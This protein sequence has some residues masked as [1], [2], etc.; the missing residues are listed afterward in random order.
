[1]KKIFLI[2]LLVLLAVV[3]TLWIYKYKRP[4]SAAEKSVTTTPNQTD[5]EKLFKL[6]PPNASE[7]QIREHSQ[8][9]A[10]LAFIG[11][12]VEINDCS[13]KPIVLQVNQGQSITLKNN[14]TQTEA[15]TIDNSNIVNITAKKEVKIKASFSK[16]PG[17]YGYRC[18]DQKTDAIVGFIAVTD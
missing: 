14:G 6:P 5:E 15:I 18:K 10:K 4:N 11:T 9:A 2:I 7:E 17:L 12:E 16:G 8:I 3:L 13:A 1:M